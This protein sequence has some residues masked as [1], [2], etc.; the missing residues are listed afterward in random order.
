MSV[1]RGSTRRLTGFP[2]MLSVMGTKPGPANLAGASAAVASCS[3]R[4]VPS[5]P[6]PT[7]R[8]LMK[9]RREKA[10]FGRAGSS[11]FLELTRHLP[12]VS[13]PSN[14][15]QAALGE[16]DNNIPRW[17]RGRWYNRDKGVD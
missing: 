10:V 15:Y 2:L 7:P 1:T 17:D 8:P 6:P 16:I 5:A 4:P 3:R 12:F 14:R 11:S 9:P 13:L